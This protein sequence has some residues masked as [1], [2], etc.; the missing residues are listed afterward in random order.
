MKIYDVVYRIKEGILFAD[1]FGMTCIFDNTEKKFCSI[2]CP[3]FE[4]NEKEN[5]VILYCCKR[6]IKIE[7][8]D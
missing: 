8:I 1:K 6:K 4:I 7:K 3:A 2:F 5:Y